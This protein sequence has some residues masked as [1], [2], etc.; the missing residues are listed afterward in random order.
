MQAPF[1]LH[2]HFTARSTQTDRVLCLSLIAKPTRAS[3]WSLPAYLHWLLRGL[4]KLR[5]CFAVSLCGGGV[6]A[7][8][9]LGCCAERRENH[10]ESGLEREEV[11]PCRQLSSAGRRVRRD[12]GLEMEKL[13]SL[14]ERRTRQ[15]CEHKRSSHCW[16]LLVLVVP[17]PADMHVLGLD[18]IHSLQQYAIGF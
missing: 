6:S 12:R 13:L 14:G 18:L 1:H 11:A 17:S 15:R 2:F 7:V 16:F 8:F 3:P 9:Y 4:S 5:G 10:Q